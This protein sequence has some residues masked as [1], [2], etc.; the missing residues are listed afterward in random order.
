MRKELKSTNIT[1]S[2]PKS[3]ELDWS[4]VETIE[5]I[6][7]LLKLIHQVGDKKVTLNLYD[8]QVDDYK[9]LFKEGEADV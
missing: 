3:F 6:V 5:D 2:Q 4:K 1:L 7:L 8:N 9:H